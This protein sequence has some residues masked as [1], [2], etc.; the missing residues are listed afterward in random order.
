MKKSAPQAFAQAA[1]SWGTA[2]FRQHVKYYFVN[3]QRRYLL[4]LFMDFGGVGWNVAKMSK[5]SPLYLYE[6]VS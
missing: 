5:R 1:V 6:T 4:V 2:I 3:L